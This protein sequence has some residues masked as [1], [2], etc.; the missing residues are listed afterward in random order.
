MGRVVLLLA[1]VAAGFLG[2]SAAHAQATVAQTSVKPGGSADIFPVYW[3]NSCMSQLQFFRG[4]DILS[5]PPGLTLSLRQQ[6]VMAARQGCTNPVP[7]AIVVVSAGPQATGGPLR[8][9]VRYTLK[10]GAQV[11]SG[12]TR[13]ITVV[14]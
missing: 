5:G 10:D 2:A 9:R 6:D 11:E 3:V 12:H 14:P 1:G 13:E 4:V 7:G 8:F